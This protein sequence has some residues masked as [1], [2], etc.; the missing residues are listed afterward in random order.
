MVRHLEEFCC[1][2]RA[3]IIL[4]KGT[5][6][7][8]DKTQGL[9]LCGTV[10]LFQ[11]TTGW[12]KFSFLRLR[13]VCNPL[14]WMVSSEGSQSTCPSSAEATWR[15]CYPGQVELEDA[16]G[17]TEGIFVVLRRFYGLLT[18]FCI[19]EKKGLAEEDQ[20]RRFVVVIRFESRPA[21]VPVF[22]ALLIL[23]CFQF[24]Y[25]VEELG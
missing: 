25:E 11:T 12:L 19:G 7:L 13:G 23:Q 24:L 3:S 4:F 9:L 1:Q 15:A 10:S 16:W 20:Y 5:V 21:A 6:E 8:T 22:T 2:S 18:G 14:F 17:E